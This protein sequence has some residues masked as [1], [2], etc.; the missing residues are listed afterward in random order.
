[1]SQ[2][3]PDGRHGM[4]ICRDCMTNRLHMTDVGQWD[5]KADAFLTQPCSACGAPEGLLITTQMI[6]Y[7]GVAVCRECRATIFELGS[8]VQPAVIVALS[9]PHRTQDGIA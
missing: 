5:E 7:R 2:P 3:T 6:A 9:P 1:M 4:A 8:R